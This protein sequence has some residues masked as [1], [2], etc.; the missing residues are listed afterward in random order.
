MCQE[1][2]IALI[3]VSY[4]FDVFRHPLML[5]K[6]AQTSSV[7]IRVSRL[8]REEMEVGFISRSPPQTFETTENSME[9]KFEL[10]AGHGNEYIKA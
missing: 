8:V 4:D 7:Q 10:R 1:G 3:T 6:H 9:T 5:Y 2:D